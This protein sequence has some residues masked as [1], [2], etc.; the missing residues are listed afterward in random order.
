MRAW[1]GNRRPPV[2]LVHLGNLRLRTALTAA[3]RHQSGFALARSLSL[4]AVAVAV[5]A[6][7]VLLV[8]L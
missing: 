2:D 8:A 3:N 5:V 1:F 6:A 7:V 4:A